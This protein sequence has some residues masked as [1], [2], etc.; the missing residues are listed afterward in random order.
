MTRRRDHKSRFLSPRLVWHCQRPSVDVGSI[1]DG[2]GDGQAT[3]HPTLIPLPAGA[4]RKVLNEIDDAAN[5]FARQLGVV[6]EVEETFGHRLT[7]LVG[8]GEE[9]VVHI[10]N[11]GS[12]RRSGRGRG[13][14]R[15]S[16]EG[17][18]GRRSRGGRSGRWSSRRR[19]RCLPG[20]S[21]RYAPTE[22]GDLLHQIPGQLDQIAHQTVV[23]KLV[24][25]LKDRPGR[26]RAAHCRGITHIG[27]VG[28]MLDVLP[29]KV[30]LLVTWDDPLA[31][32][33]DIHVHVLRAVTV[34]CDAAGDG[35]GVLGDGGDRDGRDGRC[36]QCS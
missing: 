23:H 36:G 33:Y 11:G 8:K 27:N 16:T 4:V 18:K 14:L 10:A 15:S 26:R 22:G 2:I 12:G 7:R 29:P 32:L 13:R 21:L 30:S 20:P 24:G 25:R 35:S 34:T 31:L 28:H 5:L 9:G 19:R 17:S 6:G 3:S 1:P